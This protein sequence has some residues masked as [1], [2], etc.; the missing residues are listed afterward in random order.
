MSDERRSRREF[1]LWTSHVLSSSPQR[2]A[3]ER[4]GGE[5]TALG[6]LIDRSLVGREGGRREERGGADHRPRP[7]AS[8]LHFDCGPPWLAARR[9]PGV[10]EDGFGGGKMAAEV[11]CNWFILINDNDDLL[12]IMP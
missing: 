12:R 9:G 5:R 1:Q 7:P 6:R 2:N 10:G 8:F 3:G 4:G 11:D